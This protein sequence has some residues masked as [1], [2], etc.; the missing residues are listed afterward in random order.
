MGG[1]THPEDVCPFAH[2]LASLLWPAPAL[3][4]SSLSSAPWAPC[5]TRTHT[6]RVA[7]PPRDHPALLD[8]LKVTSLRQFL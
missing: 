3:G 8:P 1:N 5:L 6:P 2:V 7:P 4:A